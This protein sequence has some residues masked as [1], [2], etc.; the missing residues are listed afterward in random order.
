MGDQSIDLVGVA[1]QGAFLVAMVT[2]GQRAAHEGV[3]GI[4]D[5]ALYVLGLV[6]DAQVRRLLLHHPPAAA[7]LVLPGNLIAHLEHAAV[8]V[9][10]AYVVLQLRIVFQQLDREET[11][12]KIVRETVLVEFGAQGAD[13]AFQFRAVVH[14]D[15]TV[16][17]CT[18]VFVRRQPVFTFKD[19][20]D[21]VEEAVDAVAVTT[22]GGHDRHTQKRAQLADIQIVATLLQFIV[23]IQR[24]HHRDIHIDKLGGKI[25]VA[26]QVAAV[27]HVQDNIR[28]FFQNMLAHI[29][30]LGRVSTEAVGARQ[31]HQV[32]SVAAVGEGAHLLVHGHATVVA[33]ALMGVRSDIEDAGLAAVRVPHQRHID[34]AAPMLGNVVYGITVGSVE[35]LVVVVMGNLALG[36]RLADHLHLL[37]IAPSQRHLEIH[38]P[39]F[40]GVVQRRVEHSLDHHPIDE[41]HLDDTLAES[42]VARH[43]H[44][45]T[46]CTRL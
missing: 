38:D 21:R 34:G 5:G 8:G 1:V 24:H 17:R 25:E 9:V 2:F 30:F 46:P 32:E 45:H 39:V 31:V 19:L 42:A 36:L 6:L 35:G 13:M 43:T 14:V 28:I 15:V 18:V 27:H 44:H 22:G 40:D 7:A 33:Y 26:F 4:R 10:L 41:A 37:R 11:C 12:G 16:Q 3:L 20:N 23:H 29:E